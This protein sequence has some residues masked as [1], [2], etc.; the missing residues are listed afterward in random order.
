MKQCLAALFVLFIGFVASAETT[1]FVVKAKGSVDSAT[2][3]SVTA[4]VEDAV[5][6]AGDYAIS[7]NRWESD[8]VL[9]PKLLKLGSSYI[10]QVG[11]Y[12]DKKLATSKK[13]KS[14]TIED[15]D[16]VVG[17]VVRAVLSDVKVAE[18]AR[19]DEV[20]KD[21]M[22]RSQVR[23]QALK[24]WSVG[25]GAAWAGGLHY[26]GTGALLLGGYNF[27][28]DPDYDLSLYGELLF[29]TGD[30]EVQF[31][32]FSVTMSWFV[33]RNKTAPYVR[34]GLGYGFASASQDN[35][36]NT[37][38]GSNDNVSSFSAVIGGGFKFFRTS[39]VH[40]G[41]DATTTIF[42]SETEKSKET[43]SLTS[44]KLV[45]SY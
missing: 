30:S 31:T 1:V 29:A 22:E 40:M 9:V 21:E 17:R 20:T 26:P 6:Q 24:Q 14:A 43:P 4:L 5:S 19:V 8:V 35:Q 15:M 39:T 27:G 13:M 34:G 16:T 44:L 3:E 28:V 41:L 2:L 45:I 12:V 36:S 38:I 33:N 23:Y 32:N 37:L 42:F 10:L 11:K 25:I 18:T 7:D